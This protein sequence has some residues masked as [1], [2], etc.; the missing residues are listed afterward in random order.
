MKMLAV[1]SESVIFMFLGLALVT[2]NYDIQWG[3]IGFTIILC[4][5]F[6]VIGKKGWTL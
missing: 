4:Q 3:F 1:A 6:R 5:L 2:L